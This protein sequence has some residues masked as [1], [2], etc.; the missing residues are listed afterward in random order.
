MSTIHIQNT[1]ATRPRAV[2]KI[3]GPFSTGRYCLTV[4][5]DDGEV[6]V[7]A[8][9]SSLAL[10]RDTIEASGAAWPGSQPTPRGTPMGPGMNITGREG[11]W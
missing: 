1:D 10:I 9:A 5:G 7:F 11:S 3:N 6:K 8:D 2:V 4:A